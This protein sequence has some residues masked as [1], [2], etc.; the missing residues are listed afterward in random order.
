MTE[1]FK[2]HRELMTA[3]MKAA[4]SYIYTF[5]WSYAKM[6]ELA[7]SGMLAHEIIKKLNQ[8]DEL[9][10]SFGVFDPNE[11][12]VRIRVSNEHCCVFFDITYAGK[13]QQ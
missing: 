13:N 9:V 6:H 2:K 10:M 12:E 3:K 4:Q 1:I 5:V 7:F 8:I 11:R